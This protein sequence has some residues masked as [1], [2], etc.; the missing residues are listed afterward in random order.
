MSHHVGRVHSS[1]GN[2]ESPGVV[3]ET[4]TGGVEITAESAAWI[5]SITFDPQDARVLAALLVVAADNVERIRKTP[6]VGWGG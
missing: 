4:S 1:N 6:T 2:A 3:V 5:L